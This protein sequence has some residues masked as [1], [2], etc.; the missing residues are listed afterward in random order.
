MSVSSSVNN[1]KALLFLKNFAELNQFTIKD[2][3]NS[4]DS[5]V[6]LS[7]DKSLRN[8]THVFEN[9]IKDKQQQEAF[10]QNN[11]SAEQQWRIVFSIYPDFRHSSLENIFSS[12]IRAVPGFSE[13]DAQ[14]IYTCLIE[15]PGMDLSQ[16]YTQHYSAEFSTWMQNEIYDLPCDSILLL[17]RVWRNFDQ[18]LR[19]NALL[20]LNSLSSS[21]KKKL[22][23]FQL[24]QS[25]I[26]KHYKALQTIRL[27][28]TFNIENL[29]T[30]TLIKSPRK[31]LNQ[32]ILLVK[33][34]N[35]LLGEVA[36]SYLEKSRFRILGFQRGSW[37]Y[38]LLYT[39]KEISFKILVWRAK[40]IFP[41]YQE[42]L[43][44]L[45]A[46]FDN[47]INSFKEAKQK[48]T[49]LEY[50]LK[51]IQEGILIYGNSN[52]EGIKAVSEKKA[53]RDKTNKRISEQQ[54][55]TYL[56]NWREKEKSLQIGL[57]KSIEFRDDISHIEYLMKEL[58]DSFQV[59]RS[60]QITQDQ[61][62]LIE[63]NQKELIQA[64]S[65]YIPSQRK[66]YTAPAIKDSDSD[67]ESIE[68]P[69]SSDRE[70]INN[71]STLTKL[72]FAEIDTFLKEG[73]QVDGFLSK[74]IIGTL[75]QLKTQLFLESQGCVSDELNIIRKEKIKEIHTQLVIAT[76]YL[77]LIIQAVENQS[78]DLVL[79][80]F[81]GSLIHCHFA[82]EQILSLMIL[83]KKGEITNTHDLIELAGKSHIDRWEEQKEFL[84]DMGIHLWFCYAE[85][86][87]SF[88][89]EESSHPKP[90]IFLQKL[91][92]VHREKE[93]KLDIAILKEAV[94][95]C[96]KMYIQALK[97]IIQSSSFSIKDL[98]EFLG[99]IE[100]IQKQTQVKIER[101]GFNKV[102]KQDKTPISEKCGQ[103]LNLL[104]SVNTL[105]NLQNFEDLLLPINTIKKYL[106]LMRISLE[107]PQK[108][109][110]LQKFIQV[111]TLANMDKLF[112]HL[113]RAIIFL[114]TGENNYSH[115]LL[116]LLQ[117]TRNFY[118]KGLITEK[119][120]LDLKDLNISITHHYLHKNSH[121]ILKREYKRVW[122]LA[123]RLNPLSER[124]LVLVSKGKKIS[125]KDLELKAEKVFKRIDTAFKLFI[126][127]LKPVITEIEELNNF[128]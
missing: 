55:K 73:G 91:F 117:L 81:R 74:V 106:E 44:P 110:S 12:A 49:E 14:Q 43:K 97:F 78:S 38:Q 65:E 24:K 17:L 15:K 5:L 32:Y 39:P 107:I 77:E 127:L 7:V 16:I 86:Y 125:Y 59:E 105:E 35:I 68:E 95:L 124:D 118:Q 23:E 40:N 26:N 83:I 102:F 47:K 56:E 103:A 108:S 109:H 84:K 19:W 104:K 126:K 27:E 89:S 92:Q 60:E 70:L 45:I 121:V 72:P 36:D 116:A 115:N 67:G 113:F 10:L 62:A 11:R 48:V 28:S 51:Q 31:S 80:G 4:L 50:I 29:S 123:Y 114:Q 33:A 42:K 1:Q 6:K 25:F 57:A 112:K 53:K 34:L 37:E 61:I 76:A 64:E 111:E 52:V 3:P 75:K 94:Q 90:F 100:E 82:I 18:R 54:I 88:H 20:S 63:K 21:H 58:N 99:K 93:K 71:I 9:V 8:T 13:E 87:Q 119:D 66:A 41:L 79:L 98:N 120:K 22:K 30:S 96:F 46:L 101:R 122:N 85:D 69:N 128:S 2:L